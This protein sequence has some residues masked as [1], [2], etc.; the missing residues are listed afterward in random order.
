MTEC[1]AIRQLVPN[2]NT[3]TMDINQICEQIRSVNAQSDVH[4]IA[5]NLIKSCRVT[6]NEHQFQWLFRDLV[7]ACFQHDID[8]MNL[9]IK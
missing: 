2:Q 5:Q 4:A 6:I 1:R 3:Q 9:Y 7:D 8:V